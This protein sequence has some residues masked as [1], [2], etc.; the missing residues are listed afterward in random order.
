MHRAP[1]LK[2]CEIHP[3]TYTQQRAESLAE[4]HKATIADTI[5]FYEAL[6]RD[7]QLVPTPLS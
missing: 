7:P 2:T 4:N 3:C 5:P 6:M 1:A